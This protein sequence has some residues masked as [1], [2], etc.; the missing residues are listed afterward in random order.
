L[1]N[2]GQD[3]EVSNSQKATYQQKGGGNYEFYKNIGNLCRSLQFVS[4]LSARTNTRSCK[5][6]A[7]GL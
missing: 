6:N 3:K 2:G 4:G 5:E 7:N 1:G